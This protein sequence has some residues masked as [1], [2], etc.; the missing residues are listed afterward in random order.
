MII[1][2]VLKTDEVITQSVRGNDEDEF[3]KE[4]ERDGGFLSKTV[5]H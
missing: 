4:R 2:F 5:I 3:E 1:I